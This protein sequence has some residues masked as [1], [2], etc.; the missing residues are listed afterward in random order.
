MNKVIWTIECDEIK[1]R[2]CVQ[3][4]STTEMVGMLIA[5]GFQRMLKPDLPYQEEPLVFRDVYG[6]TW[7]A[8][9]AIF[10]WVHNMRDMAGFAKEYKEMNGEE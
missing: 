1:F 8:M 2:Q 7:S 4:H 3:A 6:R 5:K 9:P 10:Q